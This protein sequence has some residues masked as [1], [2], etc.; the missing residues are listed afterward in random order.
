MAALAGLSTCFSDQ[1]RFAG[2]RAAPS[3][4]GFPKQRLSNTLPPASLARSCSAS[5]RPSPRDRG[6]PVRG[7]APG[8][9]DA[10]VGTARREPSR[11]VGVRGGGP[12]LA[13]GADGCVGLCAGGCARLLRRSVFPQ[14][15]RWIEPWSGCWHPP[16]EHP[17]R[18]RPGRR[19]GGEGAGGSRERF[20]ERGVKLDLVQHALGEVEDGGMQVGCHEQQRQEVARHTLSGGGAYT[21]QIMA[22]LYR[23]G[24][25][26]R[27]KAIGEPATGRTFQDLLPAIAAHL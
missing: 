24:T 25:G 14:L 4:N 20:G 13:G 19:T 5:S 2:A 8:P 7:R 1:N 26:W 9:G 16:P 12:V 21:A 15:T 22:K 27:L 6:C 18:S 23:N 17:T 3:A 10:G 11:E